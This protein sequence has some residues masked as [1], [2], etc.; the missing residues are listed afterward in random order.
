MLDFINAKLKDWYSI[1]QL[2]GLFHTSRG[3][4][5]LPNFLTS[6]NQF[7]KDEKIELGIY[8]KATIVTDLVNQVAKCAPHK[9]R[10]TSSQSFASEEIFKKEYFN[11]FVFFK[12]ELKVP[13]Q[14]LRDNQQADILQLTY[15]YFENEM[16]S[17][18]KLVPILGKN[19]KSLL[20]KNF[21]STYNPFSSFNTYDP[22]SI[23]A[24]HEDHYYKTKSP[25]IYQED[26]EG[27]R[28]N[29]ESYQVD[30]NKLNDEVSKFE[31][32]FNFRPNKEFMESV[33]NHIINGS[34]SKRGALMITYLKTH[35][36]YILTD[37]QAKIVLN[38]LEIFDDRIGEMLVDTQIYNHTIVKYKNPE[39][40]LKVLGVDTFRYER[41]YKDSLTI[42]LEKL[43]LEN[44]FKS[45]E[46]EKKEAPV[47]TT[48]IKEPS[49]FDEVVEE[50][51][52]KKKNKI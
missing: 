39:K 38:R 52:P 44:L 10:S 43:K 40:A 13:F 2:N 49:F 12:E 41:V 51:K 46:E 34:F 8:D 30:Q 3:T 29:W 6:L 16:D 32:V 9:T 23:Y 17:F 37:N 33:V 26:E 50:V 5:K 4:Y 11:L 47:K 36:N 7:L 1:H 15:R 48:E 14:K 20:A 24:N 18:L 22:Y 21:F 19:S 31:K 35:H 25:Y 42:Y 27:K 45:L 28:K